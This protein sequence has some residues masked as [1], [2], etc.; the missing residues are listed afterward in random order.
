M[1]WFTLLNNL[2]ISL[3]S[4]LINVLLISFLN[5]LT[6]SKGAI[7]EVLKKEKNYKFIK[8]KLLEIYNKLKCKIIRHIFSVSLFLLF[9]FITLF[10]FV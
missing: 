3:S 2:L 8:E 10:V 4:T 9:F 1:L 7:K 5:M 6:H